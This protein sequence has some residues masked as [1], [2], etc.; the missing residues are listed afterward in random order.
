MAKRL[1]PFPSRTRKCIWQVLLQIIKHTDVETARKIFYDAGYNSGKAV[2]ENL[3]WPVVS[4]NEFT[5]TVEE[6]LDC[7]GR[8]CRRKQSAP[9]LK[10]FSE[11]F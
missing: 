2:F 4:F 5:L 1:H 6:D 9:L 10:A 8:P 3:I 11:G 7:S